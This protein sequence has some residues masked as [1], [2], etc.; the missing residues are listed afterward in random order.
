M[1]DETLGDDACLRLI[2]ALA[3]GDP[4]PDISAI[5]AERQKLVPLLAEI[6]KGEW[7]EMLP[8]INQVAHQR[9]LSAQEIGARAG[10]L[11]ACLNPP[12]D[13]DYYA[14]LGVSPT[15]TPQEI[16]NAWAGR[17]SLY[18]PDR[19]PTSGD[20]FTRQAARLN[21][22]YHSLKDPARRQAYD[23]RR[24]REALDKQRY[25]TNRF[26]PRPVSTPAMFGGQWRRRLPILVT[27]G[28]LIAAVPIAASLLLVRPP[29]P[30]QATLSGLANTSQMV[31]RST[32]GGEPNLVAERKGLDPLRSHPRRHKT[33]EASSG[34]RTA[35]LVSYN[36]MRT[37][38]PSAPHAILAQALP[39]FTPEPKGLERQEID[40]LLDEY[41]DAYEKGDLE[42]LVGTL[43]TKVRERGTLDY[44]AIRTTYAKG[45]AGRD[46]II[47]RTKNVQVQIKGDAATVIA[48]YLIS[49][50]N[51]GQSQKNVTVSGQIE[52]KIQR[53]GDKPKIVSINY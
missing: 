33:A 24:R 26:W 4:I 43:S 2:E 21:E 46:Q 1:A 12:G 32:A 19:H 3:H 8:L 45:F 47:Y 39:P 38:E 13:D 15:A 10:F 48:Q 11:L 28:S 42:R 17:M 22:A 40:A 20:W 23:D 41:V 25:A 18:H 14:L 37:P 51:A 50:R 44:Q 52:W 27:A 6:S 5:C 30:P 35:L 31:E 53:E 34:N 49:A 36:P 9:S 29:L 7:S 16:R